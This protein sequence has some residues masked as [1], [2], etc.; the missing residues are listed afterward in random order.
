MSCVLL[1]GLLLVAE[2]SAELS[3][4]QVQ[5]I[6]DA[7]DAYSRGRPFAVIER[8]A[9][10]VNRT[11][12]AEFAELS[13]LL[14]DKKF[15]TAGFM[16]TKARLA[17]VERGLANQLPKAGARE[18]Q[19]VLREI[20]NLVPQQIAAPELAIQVDQLDFNQLSESLRKITVR[21]RQMESLRRIVDYARTLAS[22]VPRKERRKLSKQDAQFLATAAKTWIEQLDAATLNVERLEVRCR[23]RR[24]ERSLAALADK[25]LS[26]DRYKSAYFID[27]DAERLKELAGRGDLVSDDIALKASADARRGRRLA[28]ELSAKAKLLAEGLDWWYRG[29]FGRGTDFRG[30]AKSEAATRVLNGLV[31]VNLPP[32]ED[33]PS[34]KDA[35][36]LRR[37]PHARRHHLM[38]AIDDVLELQLV[39]LAPDR[40]IAWR[41]VTGAVAVT[42]FC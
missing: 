16:L 27:V 41:Q 35:D 19:L 10:L 29:R 33:A 31:W 25:Q 5:R 9:P 7:C 24:M 18:T 40:D 15:P 1:F 17:Y 36:P 8:L 13:A 39:K 23:I 26:V 42:G 28:G 30:L 21:Q 3:P 11:D 14:R 34:T 6:H 37:L 32:Q 22:T 20:G 38:W 2:P 4:R 12:E